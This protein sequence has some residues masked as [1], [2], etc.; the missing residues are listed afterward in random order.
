MSTAVHLQNTQDITQQLENEAPIVIIG[1]GPVGVRAMQSLLLHNPDEK[2]VAYGGEPW[3]PYNRV[4]LSSFLAGEMS[5]AEMV[6]SQKIPIVENVIHYSNCRVVRIDRSAKIVVD[7][8]GRTQPYRK[9]ILALGSRP[10]VPEVEGAG[11]SGVFTF[12]D[13]SDAQSLMARRVRSRVVCIVGGG[14]LGLEAAK[15][16]MRNNT[17]VV[18]IDHAPHL[19]SNQLD[20][21]AAELVQEHVLSLGVRL[22]LGSG[23]KQILSIDES[24]SGVELRNG[25]RI[26]C[27]TVIFSTG[28]VP[29]IE[30]ARN[31]GIAVGKGVRVKD[32]M[33]TADP[34]IYAIGECSQH[35]DKVY[36]LV[37]PG[38]EQASVAV[39]H[40]NGKKT[41]YVGSVAAC[42]LKIL[43]ISVFS[44]GEV[45]ESDNR[46]LI[47]NVCYS[48]PSKGI[49]RKLTIKKNRLV[50]A[51][52]IG[53]WDA[54]SR[55]QEGVSN[56]RLLWPWQIRHFIKT[57][58]VWAKEKVKSVAQWPSH[59]IVCNCMG[60]TRGTCAKAIDDGASSIDALMNATSASTVC[61]S[62]RP[63]LS[64]LLGGIVK[65]E[66]LH[67]FKS[68]FALSTIALLSMLAAL[69]LPGLT[70]NGSS[71]AAFNYDL[72]WREGLYKQITGFSIVAMVLIGLI[73]S[74]RKRWSRF[75]WLQFSFWRYLHVL[76]G[77][78]VVGTLFLHTGF[79]L[80]ENL[81]AWLMI[82]FTMLAIVGGMYGIFL[83]V[84]HR[85]D[86][87]LAK[88]TRE[89]FGW[90]HVLLAW[91]IPALVSFHVLK[92]YYF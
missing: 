24:V 28:I 75:K 4:K 60:V 83:S 69:C 14:L 31:A 41:N 35:R 47:Q 42:R 59:A 2:I 72:L 54:L 48:Q 15:A 52:A 65:A 49:Y 12:R 6:D 22:Y 78:L 87:M 8:T 45:L 70:Y 23:V 9:L 81:N 18:M 88:Q 17:K 74:L 66:K 3:E 21:E 1:M 20:S 26:A 84:Q 55:L 25:K 33:Q 30:L 56:R 67:N 36:G 53:D 77:V 62:C 37:A 43:N 38:L 63:L 90:I 16:M 29:N 68:F 10:H 40:I 7:E 44:M 46:G 79:R 27:D 50:G 61:G 82:T 80:G 51:I 57:G 73:L 19:M 76:L 5:W 89:I 91:P 92:T 13:M 32:N 34:N 39:A 85:M 86:G 71:Q 64:E 11:L 58:D